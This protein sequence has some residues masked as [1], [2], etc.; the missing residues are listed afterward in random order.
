MPLEEI[1]GNIPR[2]T[3]ISHSS[4]SRH[5]SSSTLP[6]PPSAVQ[7]MLKTTTELGDLGRFS[8]GPSRLPRSGSRIQTTRVRSGSYDTSFASALRHDRSGYVDRNGRHHGPRPMVSASALSGRHTSRSNLSSYAPSIQSRRHRPG[9]DPT[10]SP[11]PSIYT[12]RSLATLRSQRD[13]YSVRSASPGEHYTRVRRPP[14]R[15]SSPA[16]TDTRSLHTPQPGFYRAPS[17]GNVASSPASAY[18][19]GPSA[20][21]YRQDW[22]ASFDSLHMPSVHNHARSGPFPAFAPPMRTHTPRLGGA[23]TPVGGMYGSQVLTGI[24]Q[25]PTG[26][27]APAYYDYSESFTEET[28]FSPDSIEPPQ[29]LPLTINQTIWEGVPTPPLRH[30]QT[31][32]GVREGSRFYPSE[33]PTKHNRRPSEQSKRS[34]K[35]TN[36]PTLRPHSRQE[37][38]RGRI[39]GKLVATAEPAVQVIR[40][41]EKLPSRSF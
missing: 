23:S 25:S 31:P 24:P 39:N 10:A 34:L 18:R 4:K 38:S 8:S 35:A 40:V 1:S 9:N 19:R 28:C 36:K 6:A 32:F 26:S 30:A 29:E 15:A 7:S 5:E 3:S 22:N 13:I 14:Y 2:S 37:A 11:H 41:C 20:G 16:Y 33:L 12:H 21:P 17:T 27:T